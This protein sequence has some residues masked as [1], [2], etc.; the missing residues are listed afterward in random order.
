[1]R[2]RND[3][4]DLGSVPNRILPLRTPLRCVR[5][6]DRLSLSVG[7]RLS[8]NGPL[9]P[10]RSRGLRGYPS[11]RPSLCVEEASVG[12]EV[13]PEQ[14]VRGFPLLNGQRCEMFAP[15]SPVDELGE[16]G[17]QPGFILTNLNSL[18]NWARRR[19]LGP[20]SFGLACRA[21]EMA[22]TGNARVGLGRF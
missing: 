7:G 14:E 17:Y 12:M 1:M 22:G 4:P 20:A 2:P 19:S 15:C 18:Y 21:L 16:L 13:K 5:R 11:R 8:A 3:R 9:C 10:C 6:R